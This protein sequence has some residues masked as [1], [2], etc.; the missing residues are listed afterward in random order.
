[1][2]LLLRRYALRSSTTI[3]LAAASAGIFYLMHRIKVALNSWQLSPPPP[4]A[5]P[6]VPD[7]PELE[8]LEGPGAGRLPWGSGQV[9]IRKQMVVQ[10]P[11]PAGGHLP[12]RQKIFLKTQGCA[13][14]NSDSEFMM[15]LLQSYGYTF[16]ETWQEADAVLVN[17]CTVKGPSQD[18]AVNLV[19]AV[20]ES[21]KAV[22]LAGCVPTADASLAKSLEGVSMLGV[23]QLDRVVEVVEQALQG[24]HVSLL[25]HRSSM[26]SLDLPKVRK[27][28]FIEII[29]IS[30]GCLGNCSYCK[31]K[32]A[33]GSLNSYSEDAIVSRALQAV[34]EGRVEVWLTSEDTGAYGLDI[35]SNIAELLRRVA[36]ALPQRVMLKLGMTNPPYMLAHIQAVAEVLKRPNVFE[37]LHVPVQ[38]GS[39]SVLRAMVREYTRA[40]F[41]LLVDGLRAEVPEIFIGTDVICGFPAEGPADHQESLELVRQY[42]FPML[43]ISQFYPRPNTPAARLKRLDGQTVKARSSE[44]TQL[45]ESYRTEGT[46]DHMVGCRRQVWFSETDEKRQQTVGHTKN[47]A[48]VGSGGSSHD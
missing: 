38:S 20:R 37:Y 22:V 39:D 46:W 4:V 7:S 15:G 34:E 41:Q 30:G 31:T 24:H 32:H 26:P 42:R 25:S 27:N 9:R 21:G 6:P 47:Y 33:R 19:K 18:S 10:E 45:F 48:K 23:S 5:V 28:Q 2:E 35:G 3:F 17:S 14:N 43:N 8:D 16:T 40:D 29:P 1:M 36:D 12:G 13:H 44:M 11:A